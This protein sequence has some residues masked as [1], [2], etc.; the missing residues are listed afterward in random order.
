[1]KYIRRVQ[2]FLAIVGRYSQAEQ[3][4]SIRLAWQ[5]ACIVHD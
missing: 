3:R 5:V 4:I 2:L 1:M